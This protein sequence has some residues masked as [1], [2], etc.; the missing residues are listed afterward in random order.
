MAQTSVGHSMIGQILQSFGRITERDVE[1]ALDFQRQEGGFFGEALLA[2]GLV[3]REELDWGLASQF[4][5]PYVFPDPASIDLETARMVSPEWAIRHLT[6]PVLRTSDTLH[7]VVDSPAWSDALEELETRSGLKVELGL[8]SATKIRE[9]IQHAF[10]E[11]VEEV[12][13]TAMEPATVEDLVAVALSTR[14]TCLGMSVRRG[15]VTGW[16]ETHKGRIDRMPMT[17]DSRAALDRLLSP[18]P[19]GDAAPGN[20]QW[21]G[22]LSAGDE[23]IDV[24]VQRLVAASG[25]EFVFRVDQEAPRISAPERALVSE[26]RMLVSSGVGQFLFTTND[27][28]VGD[29]LHHR[30]P[31]LTLE[32]PVRAVAVSDTPIHESDDL[33]VQVLPSTAAGRDKAL[34]GLR[35]FRFEAAS[36]ALDG[37]AEEWW[38][39]VASV[40]PVLFF[41]PRDAA[42]RDYAMRSGVV[43]ELRAE[44]GPDGLLDWTLDQTA[45]V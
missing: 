35:E 7:V 2:L 45:G 27:P 8:A 1:A 26:L 12:P 20:H 5:I 24:E 34:R 23:L 22:R 32:P 21:K 19:G 37:N 29:R 15:A 39:T 18:S 11:V 44:T 3:T 36:V 38:S 43:W 13:V 41:R 28:V 30:L 42:Q 33:F 14:A 17:A 31:D 4:D 9:L 10:D 25:E 16:Y 6:L 40:A